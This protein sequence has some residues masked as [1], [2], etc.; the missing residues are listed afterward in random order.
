MGTISN[1][2]VEEK[3]IHHYVGNFCL[4]MRICRGFI[5]TL[6][7]VKAP[8][9]CGHKLTYNCNLQCNVRANNKILIEVEI[10]EK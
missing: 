5:S 10:F 1:Y 4:G 7:D 8:L 6:F 2:S 9:F 3:N